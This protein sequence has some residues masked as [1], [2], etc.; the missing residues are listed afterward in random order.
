MSVALVKPQSWHE[1]RRGGVGAS[2]AGIIVGVGLST[3]ATLWKIKMELIEPPDLS[4]KENVE[5]GLRLEDAIA[6]KFAENHPELKIRRANAIRWCPEYPWAFAHLDRIAITPD[7]LQIPLQLK[8]AGKVGQWGESGSSDIP[9]YHV[10]Q[11]QHEIAVM[12][13]PYAVW[14]V[15]IGGKDYREYVVPR[16]D[17]YI[18]R[19]MAAE[20][21]FWQ[22]VLDAI[23]PDPVNAEDVV[24]RWPKPEGSVEANDEAITDVTRLASVRANLKT[25]E[26]EENELRDR[27]ALAFG[28][29]EVLTNAGIPIATFRGSERSRLNEKQLRTDKPKIAAKYTVKTSI[30][31]LRIV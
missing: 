22:H 3:P 28:A 9:Y 31:S 16:N 25:L 14:A 19:M 11:A 2:E 20:Q 15:L 5:W 18:A 27:L 8:T 23:E 6:A 17:L 29:A 21:K 1:E 30:R 12:D 26:A 24:T 7:K 10:P 4:D 13:A